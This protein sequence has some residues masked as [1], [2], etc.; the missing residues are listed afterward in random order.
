MPYIT[1]RKI[2]KSKRSKRGRA[3]RTLVERC[4]TGHIQKDTR[5]KGV[6]A[7]YVFSSS[8]T[9]LVDLSKQWV[10]KRWLVASPVT[11]DYALS[12]DLTMGT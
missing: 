9:S 10:G 2:R 4:R 12:D 1:E 8:A 3:F 6:K 11:I 7:I 5:Q